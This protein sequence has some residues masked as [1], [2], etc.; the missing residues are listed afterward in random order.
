M[1]HHM[2]FIKNPNE[3]GS[4]YSQHREFSYFDK[5]LGSGQH[6]AQ[7][8]LN[9]T[10]M[11]TSPHFFQKSGNQGAHSSLP[12]SLNSQIKPTKLSIMAVNEHKTHN[13]WLR[14]IQALW[15]KLTTV[16]NYDEIGRVLDE[17]RQNNKK[18]RLL[19]QENVRANAF[20]VEFQ[21]KQLSR[22]K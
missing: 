14:K 11:K 19:K 9:A 6:D 13:G 22:Y 3:V 8:F 7:S 21:D 20:V 2:P 10:A 17:L 4:S 18:L 16:T 15:D 12:V 5:G 1:N